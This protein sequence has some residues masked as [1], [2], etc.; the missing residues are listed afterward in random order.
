MIMVG[1]SHHGTKTWNGGISDNDD[2]KCD[3]ICGYSAKTPF[4]QEFLILSLA[5]LA[6]ATSI[7]FEGA[8][9]IDSNAVEQNIP[10]RGVGWKERAEMAKEQCKLDPKS[11]SST[12]KRDNWV[13]VTT[14][15]IYFA[16]FV[17][18]IL[19]RQIGFPTIRAPCRAIF[20]V[21]TIPFMIIIYRKCHVSE[22]LV[23]MLT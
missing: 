16:A 19:P 7:V 22:K 18:Y 1:V 15:M 9:Q 14:A 11:C 3:R 17:I 5:F 12:V 13:F 8:L 6:V 21:L 10:Q 23:K 2:V 20:I 4:I